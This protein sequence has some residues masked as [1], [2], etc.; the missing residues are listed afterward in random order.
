M[1]LALK[2]RRSAMPFGAVMATGGASQLAR[3]D[4]LHA[5]AV[6]LLWLAVAEIGAITLLGLLRCRSLDA[7]VTEL[8]GSTRPAERFGDF[9]IPVGLAVTG[10]GLAA[11]GTPKTLGCAL[12]A[13]A[14]AWVTTMAVAGQVAM[15][16]AVRRPGVVAVDGAWFLAPAALLADAVGT[17]VVVHRLPVPMRLSVEWLALVGCGVGIVGYGLVLA[18]AALRVRRAGIGRA[19]RA[20]WWVS[21]GCGG[22]AAASLGQVSAVS[23]AGLGSA[24]GRGFTTAAVVAWAVGSALLVPVVAGSLAYLWNLRRLQGSPPWPPTFSTGVYA[25]GSSQAGRLGHLHALGLVGGSAGLATVAL[26]LVTAVLWLALVGFPAATAR[27]RST[28]PPT[29]T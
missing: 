16:V 1:I 14:L 25:L 11:L 17:A 10:T 26:W 9:T 22:L 19:P 15:P 13:T 6:P 21:A 2:A 5:M 20:P 23:P 28:G 4:A 3:S 12:C 18:L 27:W 8:P 24:A 7:T 29:K